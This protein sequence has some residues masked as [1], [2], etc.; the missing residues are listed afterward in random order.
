MRGGGLLAFA[1]FAGIA[2]ALFRP[3][4]AELAGT[5]PAAGGSSADALLLAWAMA[6]VSR[7]L[8]TRPLELF[9]AGIFHPLR[10]TLA[11][12]D[13]MIGQALLG[14]P[15]W[16]ATGN[17]LLEYN[18]LALASYPAAATAMFLYAR[19]IVGGSAVP[20]FVAGIVFAFTP[21]RFA[22]PLWLQVL[23][24]PFVPLAL[25]AWLRFVARPA[26]AP[27]LAW[28]ACWV[29]HGLMGHYLAAYFALV[30]GALALFAL[31]AAPTRRDPRLW[32]GTLLAP[33]AVGLSLWPTLAPYLALRSAQGAV[34]TGGL[35]TPLRFLWPAPTTLLGRL[36][37]APDIAL[38]P[39][40]VA[41][42]LAAMGLALRRLGPN[43]RVAL[44]PS[45][46]AAVHALGLGASLLLVLAPLRWHH[47]LPGL[48]MTRNTNRALFVGLSFLAAL[49]ASAVRWLGDRV[50]AGP[51]AACALLGLALADMGRPPRERQPFPAASALPPGVAHLARLPPGAVV[52]EVADHPESL[53]RSM[54]HAVFHRHRL[55]VGYSGVVTP[56]GQYVIDRLA[57]FPS[58]G[59][60][61]LLRQLGV[62]WVLARIPPGP[63]GSRFLAEAAAHGARLEAQYDADAVFDVR[64]VPGA[65]P[66]PRSTRLPA[67]RIRLS[68]SGGDD[69]VTRLLDGDPTTRWHGVPVPHGE[70]W[71]RV[72][73]ARPEPV[74]AL[75]LTTAREHAAAAYR[76]QIAVAAGGEGWRIVEADFEPVDLGVFLHAPPADVTF[77]AIVE[78]LAVRSLRLSN[79][80]VAFWQKRL[81]ALEDEAARRRLPID[82]GWGASG[83]WASS[84]CGSRRPHRGRRLR[85]PCRALYRSPMRRR[86]CPSSPCVLCGGRHAT[87][88][89]RKGGWAHVRCRAC[90]LVS[91]DPLPS[92]AELAAHHE[93]S[94]AE[95]AYAAFAAAAPVRA[96][97]ARDRLARL[98][99]LAR[100]GPWLD[101]GASAGEF[102]A[103]VRAAGIDAEGIEVAGP[104][105]DL[106]RRRGLPVRQVAVESF[107]PSRSF[108]VITALD[109]AEH[110]PSPLPVL[111][112]LRAWLLPDGLLALTVPNRASFA[113]RLLGR[114]WYYYTAPDHV[115]HFTPA[116]IAR[117]LERAGF[118]RI[119]VRAV[120]KPLPIDYATAQ[121]DRMAPAL[122]PLARMLSALLPARRRQSPLQ[123]PLGE[124]LVTAQPGRLTACV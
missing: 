22:S 6:H 42:L 10:D 63:D 89:F 95:G 111:E 87:L 46:V 57:T 86:R 37:S 16:L 55:P 110:L 97:V 78:P 32:V 23:W 64:S 66:R 4:W 82:L 21:Y 116:T 114:Y 3:S 94:Y 17:P 25:L 45:F 54:Y 92:E 67:C 91:L 90:G 88:L 12:G 50:R 76:T 81:R 120:R 48:D 105:V 109:V 72:E 35:D 56:G 73:L 11:L 52:Y 112:R 79:P 47:L 61:R 1:A 59:A 122:A 19:T 33:I 38:G 2:L 15:V 41:W 99:P 96:A 62:G 43:P 93:R 7:A 36:T 26:V 118:E 69:T 77:V 68:A 121:L 119:R 103:A 71:L 53:A 40:A 9:D 14:L 44:P 34:H 100:P 108:A 30:M 51:V 74:A 117:L 60:M 8:F 13:H 107:T 101:V 102:V 49:A 98:R 27:W 20:A 28:I 115:H 124:I 39:G 75:E 29:A 31:L 85:L 24:T 104:A 58:R 70:P 123:L 83:S 84:A 113:A 106:A 80:F 65:D 5:L 18:L